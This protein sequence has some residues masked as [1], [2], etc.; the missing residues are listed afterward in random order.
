MLIL[1]YV[2]A[3]SRVLRAKMIKLNGRGKAEVRERSCFNFPISLGHLGLRL[4]AKCPNTKT[5]FKY[6][7]NTSVTVFF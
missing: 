7:S 4:L 5:H 6:Y 1:W 2:R 3:V